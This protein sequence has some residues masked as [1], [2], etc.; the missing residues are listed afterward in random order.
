MGGLLS[1]LSALSTA[2]SCASARSPVASL[3]PLLAFRRARYQIARIHRCLISHSHHF[4]ASLTRSSLLLSNSPP[5]PSD[6][7]VASFGRGLGQRQR[8]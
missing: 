3:F 5:S 4:R 6:E 1:V 2:V 7:C 8:G